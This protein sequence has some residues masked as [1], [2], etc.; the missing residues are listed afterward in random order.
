ME[1]FVS[2]QILNPLKQM[3][4]NVHIIYYIYEEVITRRESF[5][6]ALTIATHQIMARTYIESI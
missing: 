4:G 6:N 5:G 1:D 3:N 2:S